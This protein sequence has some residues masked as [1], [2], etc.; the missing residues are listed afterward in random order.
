MN[1]SRWI[2]ITAGLGSYD[3]EE[4]ALRVGNDLSSA[5]IVDNV[6]A[7][8]TKDIFNVCPV[9]TGIYSDLIK[10]NSRGFGFMSWKTELVH[11]A[12]G[13]KWGDFEGVIWID[14][15]CEIGINVIS[16]RLFHKFQKY[17][18][19]NGV[20]A[21]TLRTPE[22]EYTK[23]DLFDEFPEIDPLNCGDQIQST[24]IF[25][26]GEIGRKAAERWFDT[27]CMGTHLLDLKPSKNAEN[28]RFI[29]N[30]YDQ[31]SF[32]LVC[33]SLGIPP[34]KYM[35]TAGYGSFFSRIKGFAHPIWVSR[36]RSGH[37]KKTKLNFFLEKI[38]RGR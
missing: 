8:T 30:R 17:A 33:K 22:I 29:E 11:E 18:V 27:V 16:Q 36:N 14:A 1:N 26:H 38:S 21:F 10:S 6:I 5:A 4:A 19:I 9:T 34:M 2:A 12:F 13:G 28:P 7:V 37:T 25:F 32:S 24:W 20:A 15:G 31:S 3:F 23:Q 35:P